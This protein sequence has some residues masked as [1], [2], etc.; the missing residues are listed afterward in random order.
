MATQTPTPPKTDSP[1]ISRAQL[2]LRWHIKAPITLRRM[3]RKGLLH[4]T[5]MSKKNV[6]Y[7]WSE[8]IAIEAAASTMEVKP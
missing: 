3:E 8:V 5:R 7:Q 2:M 4:P 6:F 1:F